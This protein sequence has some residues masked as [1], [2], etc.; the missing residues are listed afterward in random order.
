MQEIL[1]QI[2]SGEN[3]G[4]FLAY[5]GDLNQMP[6]QD[7]CGDRIAA[8]VMPSKPC[9]R[10]LGRE[11]QFLDGIAEGVGWK[12]GIDGAGE[13]QS[14]DPGTEAMKGKNPQKS[15]L[16]CG[17]VGH[18]PAGAERGFDLGPELHKERRPCEKLVS[19]SVDRFCRPSDL[20]RGSQI[21]IQGR[22]D[23]FPGPMDDCDLNRLIGEARSRSGAFEVYRC[24]RNFGDFQSRRSFSVIS[25][26]M[27]ASVIETPY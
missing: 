22:F 20:S 4:R 1:R 2:R 17:P 7:D 18:D 14:I 6:K 8:G 27:Q 12:R 26:S 16:C 24:K 10:Q 19:Y 25:Q 23:H 21:G 9:G 3:L 13:S 11:T 15:F 5:P